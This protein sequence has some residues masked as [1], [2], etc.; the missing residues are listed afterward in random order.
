MRCFVLKLSNRFSEEVIQT[1]DWMIDFY[2]DA[3]LDFDRQVSTILQELS[4]RGMY[5]NTIFIIYTDHAQRNVET[6]RQPLIIHFPGGEYAGTIVENTQTIDIA[7]TILDYMNIGQPEW[8]EGESLLRT[9]SPNRLIIV[10]QGAYIEQTAENNWAIV[11][12]KIKPPFYQFGEI[13]LIQCQNWTSINLHNLS[14]ANGVIAN[15]ALPCPAEMLD[16]NQVIREQAGQ[17]LSER[18]F[19]LP[20]DW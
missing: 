16:S 3:I 11:T 4:N 2:D 7:P 12:E 1:E 17:M 6:H 9:I 13:T 20:E 15:Y 5:E 19:Q 18:G 8:A 10:S 14:M